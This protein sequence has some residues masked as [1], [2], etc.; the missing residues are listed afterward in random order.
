VHQAGARLADKRAAQPGP[1]NGPF[2]QV[3]G[4]KF[5]VVVGEE[6]GQARVGGGGD[7]GGSRAEAGD[8]RH[9]DAQ[10]GQA[11]SEDVQHRAG[12]DVFDLGDEVG[13]AG[14]VDRVDRDV[15]EGEGNDV[16]VSSADRRRPVQ[17][18]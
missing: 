9:G 13:V 18:I 14:R 7:G 5:L 1:R 17:P 12:E 2:V 11:G 15:A 8:G 10:R 6:L 3:R 16:P 4:E